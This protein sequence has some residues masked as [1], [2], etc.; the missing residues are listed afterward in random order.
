MIKLPH[1][2]CRNAL[3][4]VLLAAG[5]VACGQRGPLELPEKLRPVQRVEPAPATPPE[6]Q[7]DERKDER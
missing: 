1:H 4:C 6:A 7:D 5:I 3:L 2:F